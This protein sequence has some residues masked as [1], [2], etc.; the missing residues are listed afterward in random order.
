MVDDMD[1]FIEFNN[2]FCQMANEEAININILI[3]WQVIDEVAAGTDTGWPIWQ[4]RR[5]G[6]W[7]ALMMVGAGP[8]LLM[9]QDRVNKNVELIP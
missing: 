5:V 6:P 7:A 9:A 8:L 1:I 4:T 3:W 2:F